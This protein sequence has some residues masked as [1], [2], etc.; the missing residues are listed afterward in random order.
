MATA[1]SGKDTSAIAGIPTRKMETGGIAASPGTTLSHFAR[2]ALEGTDFVTKLRPAQPVVFF[3]ASTDERN[4]VVL[5]AFVDFGWFNVSGIR[6][7]RQPGQVRLRDG[8]LVDNFSVSVRGVPA[9]PPMAQTAFL[10]IRRE[11]RTLPSGDVLQGG[12]FRV[13]GL[14]AYEIGECIWSAY[15]RGEF[16]GIDH[17]K[18]GVRRLTPE[19]LRAKID[20]AVE[21]RARRTASRQQSADTNQNTASGDTRPSVSIE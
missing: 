20:A 19:E 9:S 15:C 6:I 1:A 2:M 11:S 8:S 21:A 7:R 12:E 17:E 10:H 14:N 4:R 13:G 18:A 5:D 16:A 3:A